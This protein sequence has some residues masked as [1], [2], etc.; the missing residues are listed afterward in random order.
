MVPACSAEEID[1]SVGIVSISTVASDGLAAPVVGVR[2]H[3]EGRV[4]P[5]S[6]S[7]RT[8]R[9][10][11]ACVAMVPAVIAAAGMIAMLTVARP[12]STETSG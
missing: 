3:R 9:C 11:R 10:R 4:R 1:C 12:S 8:D 6:S 5:P 7:T 2:R